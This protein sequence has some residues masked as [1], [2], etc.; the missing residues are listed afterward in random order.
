[1]A[2]PEPDRYSVDDLVVRWEPWNKSRDYVLELIREKRLE[3]LTVV[4][5]LIR[6]E[7]G[8]IT[9][10]R[11]KVYIA[12]DVIEAFE[13]RYGMVPP[14]QRKVRVGSDD[15]PPLYRIATT[16]LEALG[17]KTSKKQVLDYLNKH[18]DPEVRSLSQNQK[19]IIAAL[20]NRNTSG[21]APRQE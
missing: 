13:G 4:G 19:N 15:P 1:M 14:R 12:R 20:L 17:T 11:R 18:P 2:L 10:L 6:D 21:G 3:T 7:H 16:T 9:G 5:S 8:K